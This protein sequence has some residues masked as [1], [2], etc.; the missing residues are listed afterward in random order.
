MWPIDF[1]KSLQSDSVKKR[2]TGNILYRYMN[3]HTLFSKDC[4]YVG[5]N[6][7][8]QI[9]IVLLPGN[10][11]NLKKKKSF[12]LV[13]GSDKLMLSQSDNLGT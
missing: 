12:F 8:S 2:R 1:Q 9:C 13:G 11:Y 4:G 5:L 6:R 10:T 3:F 7:G